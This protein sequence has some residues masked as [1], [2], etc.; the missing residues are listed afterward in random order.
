MNSNTY[1]RIAE[2][3][4]FVLF[5]LV[6]TILLLSTGRVYHGLNTGI[7]WGRG[8]VEIKPS[9]AVFLCSGSYDSFTGKYNNYNVP[10]FLH[11]LVTDC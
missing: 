7:A 9:P 5:V 6:L 1:D 10:E 3:M 2:K 4:Y 8:G 11:S